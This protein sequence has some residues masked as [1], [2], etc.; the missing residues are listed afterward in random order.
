MSTKQ[1]LLTAITSL[2]MAA[3]G[4]QLATAQTLQVHHANGTTT[5]LVLGTGATVKFLDD[6]VLLSSP[7]QTRDFAKADVL[8][9][10]YTVM[11]H[12]VNGD[13]TVNVADIASVIDVM[14]GGLYWF[15]GDE[16]Q[17]VDA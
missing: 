9:F 16:P 14:A 6:R 4:F 11:R 5:D 13:G 12:D 10:T 7:S 15:P 1:L 2:M 3:A 8:R 17:E